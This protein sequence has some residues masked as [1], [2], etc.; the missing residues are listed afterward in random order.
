MCSDLADHP[1]C[2]ACMAMQV[3][4]N[5]GLDVMGLEPAIS[6]LELTPDAVDVPVP[7]FLIQRPPQVGKYSLKWMMYSGDLQGF[8]FY[9]CTHVLLAW[10]AWWM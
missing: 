2:L 7:G 6:E 1:A 9:I 3:M 4:L 5:K 10:Y 8:V